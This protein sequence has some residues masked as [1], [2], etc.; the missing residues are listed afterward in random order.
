MSR[1]RW[2]GLGETDAEG[3]G[4]DP[5]DRMLSVISVKQMNKAKGVEEETPG[6]ERTR[7]AWCTHN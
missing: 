3:R 7:K 6:E 4:R 1:A 2:T 5:E